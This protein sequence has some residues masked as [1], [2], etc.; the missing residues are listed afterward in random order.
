M[1]DGIHIL[2]AI[3]DSIIVDFT[4]MEL[5]V[6]SRIHYYLKHPILDSS[7][8]RT[9]NEFMRCL[10]K[11][12]MLKMFTYTDWKFWKDFIN[13]LAST[14]PSIPRIE[15]HFSYSY[16][17]SVST[18]FTIVADHG[19]IWFNKYLNKTVTD[20]FYSN[21]RSCFRKPIDPE[22]SSSKVFDITK[23]KRVQPS[24]LYD[25]YKKIEYIIKQEEE[26]IALDNL[27]AIGI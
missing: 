20:K 22:S 1:S 8:P 3:P 11:N 27:I 5:G 25:E 26:K 12:N 23:Y 21:N 14:N 24:I 19:E 13:N 6:I 17:Y 2:F 4:K 10:P 16:G 18:I 15:F 9:L 7:A